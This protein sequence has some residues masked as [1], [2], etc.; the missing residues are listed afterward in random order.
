MAPRAAFEVISLSVTIMMATLAGAALGQAFPSKPLK[1]IVPLGPGAPP[2]VAARMVAQKMA[3]SL[4]QPIVIE[5]RSGAGGTI[6]GL[7]AAKSPPDGYTLFMGSITSLA[8]GPALFTNMGFEPIKLFAPISLVSNAPS[9][10]VVHAGVE[11]STL[12]QFIALVKQSPG[13]YNFASPG[14]GSLPHVSTEL[15]L[16]EAGLKMVH[17]PFGASAK[18]ALALLNGDAVLFVEVLSAFGGNI[19]AGKLRALAVAAPRRIPQL[20]DVPTA[21]EAGIPGFEAGTW[22]G[23]LAPA[24]TPGA[25][26]QR[27]NGEVI[28]ALA[29]QEVQAFF[30]KQ[31]AEAQGST[32]EEFAKFIAAETAKWSKAIALSGAKAE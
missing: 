28:R 23:L 32:P 24:G 12:A 14:N 19:Q 15:F 1:V 20:P 29:T 16:H 21:A 26:I 13:K 31:N 7:A 2:D 3:E 17:I 18:S 25:I 8:M 10:I 30:A 11:A 5:N 27:L 22:S 4:A 9:V 6:G